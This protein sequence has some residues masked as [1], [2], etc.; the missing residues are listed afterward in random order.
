MRRSV[1][2]PVG[3]VSGRVLTVDP[4]LLHVPEARCA[5]CGKELDL[6]DVVERAVR[7]ATTGALRFPRRG[8][9]AVVANATDDGRPLSIQIMLGDGER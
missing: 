8:T 3:S 9:F 1:C 7:A 2:S 6:R 5:E 4:A